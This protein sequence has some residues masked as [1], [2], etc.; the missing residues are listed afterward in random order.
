MISKK[1]F[2]YKLIFILSC[3]ALFA[4]SVWWSSRQNS[5]YDVEFILSEP[6]KLLIKTTGR[7]QLA[8]YVDDFELYHYSN[9]LRK[10]IPQK[11]AS[12]VAN[13]FMV[14][15]ETTY[16]LPLTDIWDLHVDD[17]LELV[18]YYTTGQGM[19]KKEIL[20]FNKEATSAN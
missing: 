2:N 15:N 4:V 6:D 13:W 8:L 17:Q 12:M 1:I 7:G 14:Q 10:R 18:V 5:A 19:P 11:R 20:T 3:L 9:G 16:D